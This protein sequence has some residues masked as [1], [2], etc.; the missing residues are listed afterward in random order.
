V[1]ANG[2]LDFRL[3]NRVGLTISALIEA[4]LLIL[5][6]ASKLFFQ[7]RVLLLKG[8]DDLLERRHIG[9]FGVGLQQT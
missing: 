9:R 8:F 5:N 7:P 1:T 6:N 3:G 4:A 2:V